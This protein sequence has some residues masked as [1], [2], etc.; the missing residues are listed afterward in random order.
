[1]EP[2]IG[3]A[4]AGDLI[5]DSNV[6]TFQA[7]VLEASR[8]VPVVVDFW[9]PWCG[10]CKQLGP[11]L[12]KAARAA[13]G[14]FKLVKVN[15]DENQQ[16]ARTLRVQSIPAVFA[17]V[18][19]QPVD[20]FVGALPESQIKAFL[21]RLIG[22]EGP[23]ALD[24]ALA[25]AKAAQETG[26]HGSAVALYQQIIRHDAVNAAAWGGFARSLIALGQ[27]DK[28]KE[29]IAKAPP[30]VAKHPDMVGAKTEIALL[31]QAKGA[32]EVGA[33]R[34][35]IAADPK[36]YQ[37]RIDLSVALFGGGEREAAVDAL[38]ELIGRDRAWNDQAGRTQLLTFFEA[39]GPTDSV[40]VA[41][42]RK[43]SAVWF[44]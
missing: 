25:Q 4:P 38:I 16:I 17:F 42:R 35:R 18:N 3:G 22:D 33:L 12:E 19:G 5:K 44:A 28:A 20:G 1:M 24:E 31:D 27:I 30:E 37:A 21:G 2:I 9:A 15:I 34:A 7:D 39:M 36:D 43:L 32:G 14:K 23:S 26:D 8:T 10:P 40:T 13:K 11:L 41:G 6:K 29:L